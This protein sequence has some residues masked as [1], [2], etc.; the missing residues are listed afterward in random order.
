MHNWQIQLNIY[1]ESYLFRFSFFNKKMIQTPDIL[2]QWNLKTI[3]ACARILICIKKFKRKA[4]NIIEPLS[5]QTANKKVQAFLKNHTSSSICLSSVHDTLDALEQ[6][7]SPEQIDESEKLWI[8][9]A[10]LWSNLDKILDHKSVTDDIFFMILDHYYS[11]SRGWSVKNLPYAQPKFQELEI[12]ARNI[13]M[14]IARLPQ[15][16]LFQE[17]FEILYNSVCEQRR[18]EIRSRGSFDFWYLDEIKSEL[19]TYNWLSGVE[20][21]WIFLS[22]RLWLASVMLSAWAPFYFLTE[23]SEKD[24]A[25]FLDL[26][27][28]WSVWQLLDDSIDAEKDNDNGKYSFMTLK[29]NKSIREI[30]VTNQRIKN[31]IRFPLNWSSFRTFTAFRDAY[32]ILSKLRPPDNKADLPYEIW[33]LK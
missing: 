9:V 28:F 33:S 1:Y 5:Y 2:Q 16:E 3:R 17:I 26:L 6:K 11:L 8:Y 18:G 14:I 19:R 20:Q 25:A 24:K 12:I 22:E 29:W 15:K 10:I 30:F 31:I 4:L 32:P 13:A 21:D 23:F 27:H 7:L